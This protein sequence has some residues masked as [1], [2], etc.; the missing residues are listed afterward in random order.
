M[1]SDEEKGDADAGE[2]EEKERYETEC[3]H[4]GAVEFL[5]RRL[6]VQEVL[7]Q[8]KEQVG[9]QTCV[10]FVNKV[11]CLSSYIYEGKIMKVIEAGCQKVYTL[12]LY[13]LK[14]FFIQPD[15]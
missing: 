1:W 13:G 2:H 6:L 8:P 7:T 3:P 9:W 11:N 5:Q 15:W 10:K 4:N 14:K 12:Y